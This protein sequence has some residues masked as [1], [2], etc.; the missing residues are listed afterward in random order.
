MQTLTFPQMIHWFT[1][2]VNR[3]SPE[4]H[5]L[6]RCIIDGLGH[7]EKGMG[8]RDVYARALSAFLEWSIKQ[9][10]NSSVEKT[11]RQLVNVKH[12]LKQLHSM[13]NHAE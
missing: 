5:C 4:T 1:A 9:T 8:L 7:A 11:S 13:M 12:T 10:D 2:A 6:L 3:E